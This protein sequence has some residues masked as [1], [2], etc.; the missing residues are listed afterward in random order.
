MHHIYA[1]FY[2]LRYSDQSAKVKS[3]KIRS[4]YLIKV[5]A[6]I[7]STAEEV[8]FSIPSITLYSSVGVRTTVS[9][10]IIAP[11]LCCCGLNMHGGIHVNAIA[12][13]ES[14]PTVRTE[15]HNVNYGVTLS[16]DIFD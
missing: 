7:H 2:S 4:K 13:T 14:L 12:G 16:L 11:Q 8:V 3:Q 1:T 6:K 5:S 10:T 15:L 9:F